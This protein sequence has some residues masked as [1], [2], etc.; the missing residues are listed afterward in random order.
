MSNGY[1]LVLEAHIKAKKMLPAQA[2]PTGTTTESASLDLEFQWEQSW[3]GQDWEK[4]SLFD[5]YV[6]LHR[7][8]PRLP[9]YLV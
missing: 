3:R 6:I 1:R 2:T 9:P 8:T 7:G 5:V 4:H